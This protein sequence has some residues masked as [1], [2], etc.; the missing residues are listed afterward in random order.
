MTTRLMAMPEK[1]TT[2]A[3]VFFLVDFIEISLNRTR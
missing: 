1:I 2:S 3:N